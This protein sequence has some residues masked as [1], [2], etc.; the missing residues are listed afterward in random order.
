MPSE[1]FCVIDIGTG[2]DQA[3]LQGTTLQI[4]RGL[5][6]PQGSRMPVGQIAEVLCQVD[7][8][9][10]CSLD[11]GFVSYEHALGK[12]TEIWEINLV[13]LFIGESMP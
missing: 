4:L 10:G 8:M 7:D 2:N 5:C 11:G 9:Q 12:G 6:A 3:L 13:C 1:R